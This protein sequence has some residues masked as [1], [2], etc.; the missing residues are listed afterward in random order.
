MPQCG[1][2]CVFF[3]KG[4]HAHM[5][6][7]IFD[8]TGPV[9]IG[10]SSSHTAGA[11]QLARA[12]AVI[13]GGRFSHVRFSLHGSFAKTGRGHGTDKALVAGILGLKADDEQ[14]KDSFALAA[15]RGITVSFD[16]AELDNMHDNS[17]CIT[18][19]LPDG[20]TRRITGS[21]IGGGQILIRKLDDLDVEL[22]VNAPTLV[23]TQ[24]DKRG[25]ISDIS[26]VLADNDINIGVMKLSRSGKG[27]IAVCVIETD[28]A[29]TPALVDCLRAQKH[30]ISVQALNP[31]L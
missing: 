11:V 31:D 21:S 9:M 25:V 10:P 27:Q 13:V 12:A 2:H 22:S 8:V 15:E 4:R 3:H 14:L 30:V 26:R 24:H 17:V 7:S 29:L 23:I 5:N 1:L 28:S 6:I 20:S 19:T 16:E 18:F